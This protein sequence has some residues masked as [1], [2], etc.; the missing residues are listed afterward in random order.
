MLKKELLQVRASADLRD[1][2]NAVEN[3]PSAAQSSI[4]KTFASLGSMEKTNVRAELTQALGKNCTAIYSIELSA[5]ADP[6]AVWEALNRYKISK[7]DGKSLSRVHS[8]KP[9]SCMY[10]G[11]SRDCVKRLMEHFGFGAKSTYSLHLSSW[12]SQLGGEF[13]INILKY[14]NV[15]QRVLCALEDKLSEELTPLFGR[16]GSL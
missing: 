7:L 3:A 6:A 4:K 12:A 8:F 16:R 11:S 1:L 2:A 13:Q 10:V 5:E 9:T 14:D 15:E